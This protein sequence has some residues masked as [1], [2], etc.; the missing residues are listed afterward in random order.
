VPVFE[1]ADIQLEMMRVPQSQNTIFVQFKRK[2]GASMMYY[3][4]I[5]KFKAD[6]QLLNN[7]TLEGGEAQ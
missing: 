1:H 3:D 7:A 2:G 4:I 5:K 6:M